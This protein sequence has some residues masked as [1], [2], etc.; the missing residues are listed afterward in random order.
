MIKFAKTTNKTIGGKNYTIT[1]WPVTRVIRNMPRIARFF[2]VP[3]GTIMGSQAAGPEGMQDALP[4]AILYL[5][6]QMDNE[7]SF[8]L[9]NVLL[10]GVEVNSMALTGELDSLFDD[11]MD[12]LELLREILVVNYGPFFTRRGFGSLRDLMES[13]GMVKQVHQMGQEPEAEPQ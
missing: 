13:F 10:E 9:I 11:P 8:E 7:G 6:E 5:A 1:H 2:A 4:T 3:A 12:L